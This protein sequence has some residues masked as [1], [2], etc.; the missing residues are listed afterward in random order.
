[1]NKVSDYGVKRED[2]P[3]LAKNSHHAMGFLYDLTPVELSEEDTAEI[4][5]RAFA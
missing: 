2:I 5:K 4:F 3:R 1:M